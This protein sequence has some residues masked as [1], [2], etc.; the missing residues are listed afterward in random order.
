MDTGRKKIMIVIGTR[1]E[2]IKLA[3]LVLHIQR[4]ASDLYETIVVFTGQHEDL[5]GQAADVF[6]IHPDFELHAM[7][8]DDDLT[9]LTSRLLVGMADLLTKVQ[10]DLLIVQGDTTTAFAAG[11]AAFYQHIPIAHVEAGLRTRDIYSPFPE[12][13]NRT[14]LARLAT[15]NVP[16]P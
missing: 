12:E 13:V 10:P 5:V 14:I 4:T 3:P 8:A 7:H 2:M 11:L 9:H 15:I 6:G 16:P 1:P